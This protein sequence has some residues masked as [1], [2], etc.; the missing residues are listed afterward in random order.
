[1][2]FSK[3]KT[4]FNHNG[5]LKEPQVAD[6]A[7]DHPHVHVLVSALAFHPHRSLWTLSTVL[8][9]VPHDKHHNEVSD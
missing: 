4:F 8:E 2:L 1:M 7:L 6:P 3:E 9:N 5:G